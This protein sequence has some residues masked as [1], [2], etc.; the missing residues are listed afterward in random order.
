MNTETI[1]E[2]EPGVRRVYHYNERTGRHGEPKTTLFTE[3]TL[4]LERFAP[5]EWV[6]PP[7]YQRT[8]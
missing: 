7:A 3:E 4:R 8:K 6:P 2:V 5:R 1:V